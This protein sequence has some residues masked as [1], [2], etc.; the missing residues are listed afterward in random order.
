MSAEQLQRLLIA[1]DDADLV[2]AYVLFFESRG[3]RVHTAYDGIAALAVYRRWHPV[4]AICDVE[5]PRLDGRAVARAIR[6]DGAVPAP[7]LIAVTGLSTAAARDES[8]KCGFDHH[9]V[10]PAH[11]PLI[12]AAIVFR[13]RR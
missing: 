2:A 5:M 12:W 8:L 13:G 9:F 3:Y 6:Q 4:A 11:L 7:L 1:D 10:K